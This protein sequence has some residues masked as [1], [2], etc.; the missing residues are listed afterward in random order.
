MQTRI[1]DFLGVSNT[2]HT[3]LTRDITLSDLQGNTKVVVRCHA[4]IIAN[5]SISYYMDVLE[6]EIFLQY[7]D[8][9]QVEVEKFKAEAIAIAEKAGVPIL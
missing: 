3:N 6:D 2:Q 5:K 9:I 8:V 7:R 4:N 1:N